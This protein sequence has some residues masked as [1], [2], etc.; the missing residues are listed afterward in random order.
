MFVRYSWS[1][2]ASLPFNSFQNPASSSGGDG[3]TFTTTHSL[4]I[5]NNYVVS[6][7][8]LVNVR[9][10]LNR[11]YVDR[12]PLS[13]GFD[14]ASLGFPSNVVQTAQAAEFPRIDVQGFQSLGQNTFTDL[15]IAPTTHQFNLN[16]TKILSSHT[17]K[18]GMDYRKFMLN[19]LQLFF[20]A[21][22]YGFD[23]AQW[24]QRNPNVTSSTQGFALASMLLGIPSFGQISH[25]PDAGVVELLLGLLHSGRLEALEETD[26][27]SRTA[28]RVR[29]AADRAVQSSQLLR[30]RRAIAYR[31]PGAGQPVLQPVGARAAR[32]CSS[33][34]TTAGRSRPIATTSGRAIGVVLQRLGEDRRPLG[35]RG[36]LHALARAGGGPLRLGAA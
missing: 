21:G 36:L 25:N 33:T 15:V 34:R 23:N 22:Q 1:D 4:S 14:L 17:L 30:L 29:H 19:F 9:Y 31:Q 5:D 27:Q 3:P 18:F 12:K 26:R 20:P 16:A 28:L 7:S 35:L 8:F 24:T 2:E 10:G 11:R 13:A 32:W 6:P